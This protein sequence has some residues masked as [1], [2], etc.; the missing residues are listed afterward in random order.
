MAEIERV[1]VS[2]DDLE[3]NCYVVHTPQGEVIV[4]AGAEPERILE[5]L[6]D[7]ALA[8]LV[9]HGHADHIGALEEVRRATGAPVYMHPAD[10][11]PA[12]MAGYDPLEDGR[13]LQ[14]G[15][16]GF[17]VLHTPGHS[18]GSV[19]FVVG[20]DQLV[21]DLILPGSVGRTDLPGASWEEIELS[22][23]RVMSLWSER[24]R[25]YCGHGPV[26]S[27]ARE[28]ETNPYLPPE[29]P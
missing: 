27:A 5:R 1:A 25:L 9:T 20:E 6:R 4:D 18:P 16:E 12:G 22:L 13:L 23:R 29:V 28:L 10:A 14:L 7:E 2:F 15:G 26:L 11:E 3:V 8:I 24:T 21:G 17:R 19:T